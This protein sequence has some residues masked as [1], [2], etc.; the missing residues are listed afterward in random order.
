[1]TKR[2]LLVAAALAA[3]LAACCTHEVR[4]EAPVVD[5]AP[6]PPPPA[7]NVD[8]SIIDP[9]VKPCDD[10]FQY[11][12]NG[13][14]KK[15]QIPA[16]RPSWTRS[17]SE[18]DDRNLA[19]LRTYL[20]ADAAGGGDP[21]DPY[22]GKLGDFWAT[23]MDEK[24]VE[25]GGLDGLRLELARVEDVK[26]VASL[27]RVVGLLSAE[28]IEAF[29]D[30]GEGQDF[31]DATQVIGQLD[32]GGLGL[33]DRD[34]Y[35]KTD[36]HDQK[37]RALYLAHVEKMMAL[38]GEG[39][40]QAKADAQTVMR[41]E[42]ALATASQSRVL[43]RNPDNV[44]HRIDLAGVLALAP[45]FP[46]KVYLGLLKHPGITDI[47]VASPDFF[48]ALDQLLVATPAADL[49]AYLRWHV[50]ASVAQ[51]LPDAFVQEDFHF[52]S[53]AFTGADKILP[54]WKRCIGAVN[55]ALGQALARPFV[56]QT[57]GEA[58]KARNVTRVQ[59]I[60][61]AMGSELS[62]LDWMDA[63]TKKAAQEKLGLVA[64]QIGFPDQWRDYASL[65]TDRTSYLG[66]LLRANEFEVQREL[67]KIGKPVD[68]SDW[69]MNPQA[70]NAYYD[71][72]LNQ[73]V[74][75]AGILQPPF[76]NRDSD[77][78]CNYGGI[79]MVM[80]HELTHGF[81]DEGRRFDGHG[82]LREWWTPESKAH[83]E[84]R[85]KCVE[86]QYDGYAPLPDVHLNGKLTL[87]ENIADLG[88][89]KL[90]Y[91]AFER[92]RGDVK[93]TFGLSPEQQF[94]LSYAQ[95]WCQKVR[96]PYARMLVTIDP[97]SPARFR[98]DGPLSNLAAFR[99]A[100]QCKEGQP[101]VRPSKDRCEIW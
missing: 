40:A 93:A 56:R 94:F 30:F 41:L 92:H 96:E 13:W 10:F 22:R 34:Y 16:D 52:R 91:E 33:P 73:M 68:R 11:A 80:G 70:V 66:N 65:A 98:V 63:K 86:T 21:S 62:K 71:P 69:D 38:A 3:P 9:A 51:A 61:A 29:F 20:Q 19:L 44:Y 45:S 72:S 99:E 76:F 35:L 25:A 83:F 77:S 53:A 84:A 100:F 46:W 74:F 95:A 2:S 55:G 88:G 49:R 17:F 15:T 28:G 5:V 8:P 12:C 75:P 60:E 54:R 31:K 26:D 50:V 1:M 78:A 32:Q 48:K 64:N 14:I 90:A 7:P 101:M 36:E 57:F 87:G 79:G 59:A 23:C 82:N 67:D 58:G 42:T 43:R 97:H 81:D 89:L 47:N 18:I 24:A 4:A 27:G 85:A 6:P 39:E 37:I